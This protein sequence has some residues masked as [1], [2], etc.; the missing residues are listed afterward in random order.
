MTKNQKT[1]LTII[2]ISTFALLPILGLIALATYFIGIILM[3]VW[4]IGNLLSKILVVFVTLALVALYLSS[5]LL[6]PT[7]NFTGIKQEAQTRMKN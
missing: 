1:I 4:D 6:V 5:I 7:Q 3:L 2:L